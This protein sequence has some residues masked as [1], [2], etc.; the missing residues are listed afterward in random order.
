MKNPMTRRSALR[1]LT[2]SVALLGAAGSL[3]PRLGAAEGEPIK[4]KG[5]IRHSV[6]AWCYN[7][8][9]NPGKNKTPKMSFEDFCREC[10]K[11]GIESVELLGASEWPAAISVWAMGMLF[12]VLVN[13]VYPAILLTRKK[14]WGVLR[15]NPREIGLSLVVG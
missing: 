9:F 14:T 7:S 2:G 10:A 1:N 4:R 13:L 6:S 5:N 8:L 12:G 15:D 11:L 3:A